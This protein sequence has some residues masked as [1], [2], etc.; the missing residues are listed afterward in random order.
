[1]QRPAGRARL[2]LG[3]CSG[4]SADGTDLA[5]IRV[6]GTGA[7]RT[8]EFVAGATVPFPDPLRER[9]LAAPGWSL[10]EFAAMHFRLGERFGR[11]A[12]SFLEKE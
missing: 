7:Q 8:V 6:R 9:I 5:L 4:T 2:I 12:R 11:D 3:L 10:A 1:M